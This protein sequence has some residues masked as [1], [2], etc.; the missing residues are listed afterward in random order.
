MMTAS[1]DKSAPITS[2]E[3][4]LN[5]IDLLLMIGGAILTA[6]FLKK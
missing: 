1:M 2:T 6:T 4:V 5:K 3:G